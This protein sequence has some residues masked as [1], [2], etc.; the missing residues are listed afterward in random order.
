[1]NAS[2]K[3][4]RIFESLNFMHEFSIAFLRRRKKEIKC[5][6]TANRDIILTMVHFPSSSLF[7]P[8]SGSVGSSEDMG[9]KLVD[10]SSL[11]VFL[12]VL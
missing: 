3:T 4:Y 5:M 7:K 1:M 11:E 2:A 6:T 12:E 10:D 8:W 9:R